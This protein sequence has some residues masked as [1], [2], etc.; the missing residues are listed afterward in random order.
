MA[1]VPPLP[2]L[3]TPIPPGTRQNKR[4]LL[5]LGTTVLLAG[6]GLIV[7]QFGGTRPML[8]REPRDRTVSDQVLTETRSGVPDDL[9][10][11]STYA[12]QAIPPAPAPHARDH[13]GQWAACGLPTDEP[14]VSP[15]VGD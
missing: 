5:V 9:R 10:L 3:I 6:V 2:P 14:W 12:R 11:P 4:T 13:P 8:S 1:P 7:V 15:S